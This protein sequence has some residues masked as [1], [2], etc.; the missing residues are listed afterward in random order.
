MSQTNQPAIPEIYS[1]FPEFIPK[2]NDEI[3]VTLTPDERESLEAILKEIILNL[4][5]DPES[6]EELYRSDISEDREYFKL[7]LYG[8]EMRAMR[9][10]LKK[11]R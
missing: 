8:Y 6:G 3:T 1:K 2:N 4:P 11:I 9:T 10:L 7:S 5:Q